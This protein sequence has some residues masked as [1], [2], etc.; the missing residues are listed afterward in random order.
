MLPCG[1][2][3][4]DG[5]YVYDGCT[6]PA[7]VIPKKGFPQILSQSDYDKLDKPTLKLGMQTGPTL[8]KHGK[9][10]LNLK[11]EGFTFPGSLF[12]SH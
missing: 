12:A 8:V 2:V 11:G 5:R 6:G 1:D 9:A 10:A 3:V 7:F 4:V